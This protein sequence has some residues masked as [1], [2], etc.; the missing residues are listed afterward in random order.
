MFLVI[1]E[2]EPNYFWETWHWKSWQYELVLDASCRVQM[3]KR[4]F[5]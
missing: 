5:L 4:G 3:K 2:A 1:A